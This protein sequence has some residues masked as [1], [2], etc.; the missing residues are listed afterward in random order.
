MVKQTMGLGDLLIEQGHLTLDQLKEA[1]Q[2]QKE[3]QVRLGEIFVQRGW[4]SE[5]IVTRALGDQLGF[6]L[7][8][9]TKNAIEP[10]ALDFIPLEVARRF[11]VMPVSVNET[12]LTVAMADPTDVEAQDQLRTLALRSARDLKIMM[13]DHDELDRVR[14]SKYGMALGFNHQVQPSS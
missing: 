6:P 10:S 12:T 8:N 11:N 3:T 13:G 4:V 9:P 5:D 1:L 14:D 2:E 7:F